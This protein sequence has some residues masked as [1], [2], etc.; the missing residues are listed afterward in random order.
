M[1]RLVQPLSYRTLKASGDC[2]V[3]AELVLEIKTNKGTWEPMTFWVDSGTEMTTLAAD[4]AKNRDL[5]M[6][7]R[8][9]AG[10]TLHGQEVRSGLLRARI[11][12]MDATE[13]LFPCYFLGDPNVQRA[14]SINLLGLTGVINQVRFTFDGESSAKAPFGVLVVE[15]K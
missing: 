13:Y 4:Q 6:P 12:G 2:V 5:P 3:H 1:S 7:R 11:V 15:K 8:A 14:R 10:L 9:M